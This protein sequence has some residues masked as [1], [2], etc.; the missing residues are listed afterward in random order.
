MVCNCSVLCGLH[1]VAMKICL[2]SMHRTEQLP[3]FL[4][5]RGKARS[6]RLL[7]LNFPFSIIN[8]LKFVPL[9][10]SANRFGEAV[11]EYYYAGVFVRGCVRLYVILDFLL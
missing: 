6:L 7:I 4:R 11:A 10:L 9:Y 5:E 8:F 1:G 3:W 2:F